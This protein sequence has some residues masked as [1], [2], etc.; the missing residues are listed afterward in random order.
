M[1]WF[2]GRFNYMIFSIST[3]ENASLFTKT[4]NIFRKIPGSKLLM[5]QYPR[6]FNY[7]IFSISSMKNA[8][9]FTKSCNFFM[10][11]PGSKL[12]MARYAGRLQYIFNFDCKVVKYA[13][14]GIRVGKET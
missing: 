4:S 3:V 14:K 6:S 1:A 12:S 10:K 8:S 11:I 7:R 2:P 13:L 5:A 9:F